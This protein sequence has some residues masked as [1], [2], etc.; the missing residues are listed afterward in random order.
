MEKLLQDL[1]YGVRVLMKKPGFTTIAILT[2]ALGIG[3]NTAIFSVI[4]SILLRP[5]PY[6]D[7]EGLVQ[8]WEVSPKQKGTNE[9][10][11]ASLPNFVDWRDQNQTFEHLAAYLNRSLNLTEG[12]QPERVQGVL[13]SPNFF[14]LLKVQPFI[15]RGFSADEAQ[16][17]K[18]TVMAYVVTQRTNEIGIRLALGAR[19]SDVVKMVVKQGM[20]TALVGVGFGLATALALTRLMENLLYNVNGTDPVV[21]VAVSLILTGVALV[22]CLVPARR[23]A[24]TDPMVALRYE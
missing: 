7:P 10:S 3:V 16:P 2:L 8:V 15:G 19:S 1:R 6:E 14:S 22:A 18:H 5:L 12:E 24:K 21:F 17:G 9:T 23:A 11:S 20:T 4:N 13:G